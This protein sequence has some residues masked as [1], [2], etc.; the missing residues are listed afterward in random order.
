[1]QLSTALVGVLGAFFALC[2]QSPKGTGRMGP[3]HNTQ[4]N[5]LLITGVHFTVA[6]FSK[7]TF[8]LCL[9]NASSWILPFTSGGFLYIALVN[10]VP[11]LLEESSFRYDG[12]LLKKSFIKVLLL[13]LRKSTALFL[14][15]NQHVEW[16]S[17]KKNYFKSHVCLFVFICFNNLHVFTNRCSSVI[18]IAG[19]RTSGFDS[20]H[21]YIYTHLYVFFGNN[22]SQDGLIHGTP[23]FTIKTARVGFCLFICC[24]TKNKC[25]ENMLQPNIKKPINITN[26]FKY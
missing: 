6:M 2:A 13:L 22:V 14:G 12:C 3:I 16:I 24:L 21:M 26:R 9:E 1:M 15:S 10:V 19:N 18:G 23:A 5:A 7:K 25:M 20:H 11:D 8:I 17:N 4:A